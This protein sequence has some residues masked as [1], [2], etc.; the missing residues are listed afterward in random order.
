[1]SK[2][3]LAIA[4]AGLIGRAHW[5]RMLASGECELAAFAD[6]YPSAA[7][8][9]DEAGVPLYPSLEA[10]LAAQRLDGVVLATPNLLHVPG[11]LACIEAGVPV[12]LEK[13]VADT[14][15]EAI[16]LADA[17]EAAGVP[18]LVGHHRRHSAIL[19]AAR[20]TIASGRL[21]RLVAVTASATFHKPDEYFDAAWRRQKGGGPIL[22]NLVHEIDNLRALVG[23]IVEVQATG[24]NAIRGFEVED[25]VAITLRFANGA[26]GTF[27]LSDAAASPRSWEQSSGEN[28]DFDHHPDQDCYVIAG[29]RGSLQVPTLRVYEYLGAASWWNPLVKSQVEIREIDPLVRQLD[30][31]CAVVRR[32]VPPRVTVRDAIRT[33]AVTLAID[34]AARTGLRVPITS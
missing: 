31:F 27:M 21:G 26:L 30:H 25:T 24:S 5:K 9:A 13:P 1:M 28:H 12:L 22:L 4:G 18:V 14:M 20:E 3:R 33:L 6:P 32:E 15:E 16:R 11:A 34:E 2:L 7:M 19:E 17:V 23:D 8:L 10:M 29:T